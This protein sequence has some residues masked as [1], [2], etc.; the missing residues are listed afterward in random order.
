MLVFVKLVGKFVHYLLRSDSLPPQQVP[1]IKKL[2]TVIMKFL[3]TILI[4]CLLGFTLTGFGQKGELL[5]KLPETKEEYTASEKNALA[6]IDWLEN[7]PIKEEQSKRK[8][9]TALLLAWIINSPTVTVELNEVVMTF[10]KKN[11]D[12]LIYFL[13]GWTR[14]ALTN[15]YSKDVTQGSLAGLKSVIKVYKAGGFKKDKEV[16]KL[17]DLEASGK[18]EA[19]VMEQLAKK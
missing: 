8:E 11:E 17:I 19:W 2:T 12:L 13:G 18:L 15:A 5:A 3:K 16:N 10:T 4:P 9:Q 1:I 14:Y 6:S 7:T